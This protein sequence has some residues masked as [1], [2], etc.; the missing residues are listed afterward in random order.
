M[1]KAVRINYPIHNI[2]F[3]ENNKKKFEFFVVEK[4][5]I[6]GKENPDSKSNEY[7]KKPIQNWI[8]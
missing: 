6:E 4:E 2:Q 5:E 1:D 7:R 8:V 3:Q